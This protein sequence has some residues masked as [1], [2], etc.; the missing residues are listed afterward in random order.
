[1]LEAL[2]ILR[3]ASAEFEAWAEQIRRCPRPA[4]R[5]LRSELTELK[6][7]VAS[8]LHLVDAGAAVKRGLTTRF[9][10][11]LAFTARPK[12]AYPASTRVPVPPHL[13]PPPDGDV[14]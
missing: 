6:C 2:E 11:Q 5:P 8:V 10:Q 9:N 12:T 13:A 1:V 3:T 7:E 4:A 14:R